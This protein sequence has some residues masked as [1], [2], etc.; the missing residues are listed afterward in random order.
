MSAEPIIGW[1]KSCPGVGLVTLDGRTLVVMEQSMY[2][3]VEARLR[4]AEA[5]VAALLPYASLC[6]SASISGE[7]DAVDGV[8]HKRDEAVSEARAFLAREG[9]Q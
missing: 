3:V 5:I 1:S 8:A 4:E 6:F 2:E 9:E 7:S